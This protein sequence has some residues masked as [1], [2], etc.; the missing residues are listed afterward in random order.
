MRVLFANHT[1]TISGAGISLSLLL[2]SLPPSVEKFFCLH[3]KSRIS[4]DLG[5]KNDKTYRD[6]FLSTMHTTVYGSG[7]RLHLR[8]FHSLKSHL[9]LPT[10]SRLKSKWNLQLVH[11][12]ETSLVPYALAASKLGIPVLIHA[13]TVVNPFSRGMQSLERGVLGHQIKFV[14][15]DPETK[16]SLPERCR[17]KSQVVY[18][19]VFMRHV[20]QEE[21][22]WKRRS[23]RIPDNAVVVGQMASLHKEKGVWRI[24]ELASTICHQNPRI[25]FVLAGDPS[26]EAGL[27]PELQ[28]AIQNKGLQNNFHLV[29][30]EKDVA[31]AYAGFDIALCLFGE[32]LGAVGRAGYEAPLAGRP[33]VATIP[34]FK[35]SEAV[36]SGK[37][38][39]V[40][41]PSDYRGVADAVLSLANSPDRRR[42]LGDSAKSLIGD[43]HDPKKHAATI[44]QIY[45]NMIESR[46]KKQTA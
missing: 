41:E 26:P 32:F 17:T 29:G 35:K 16:D 3:W 5:A 14:C 19:P 1:N 6:Y 37:T 4:E 40:F 44:A 9:A 18:N 33:L 7:M 13:R 23:W 31:L 8:I 27:G 10:L 12:N 42:S 20:S 30:Y 34:D 36:V 15:I 11:L 28:K 24:L 21:I 46:P 43:R 25:H 38:G 45:R 22:V 2:H 39:L